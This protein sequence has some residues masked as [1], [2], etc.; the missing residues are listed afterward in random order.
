[1]D[2]EEVD[3]IIVENQ[4]WLDATKSAI[5]LSENVHKCPKRAALVRLIDNDDRQPLDDDDDNLGN[6]NP[7]VFP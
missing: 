4:F 6:R 1:M 3:G 5:Q 7:R 2:D